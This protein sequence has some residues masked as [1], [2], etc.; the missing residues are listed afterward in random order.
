MVYL[1]K[2]KKFPQEPVNQHYIKILLYLKNNGPKSSK[3]LVE[4]LNYKPKTISRIL[5]NLRKYGF[6]EVVWVPKKTLKDYSQ[7]NL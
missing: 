6:V 5:Q 1:W 2:F 7:E 3:E 4:K